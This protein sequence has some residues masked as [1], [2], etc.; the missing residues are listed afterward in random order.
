MLTAPFPAE[1]RVCTRSD[2]DLTDFRENIS[3]VTHIIPRGK[4][5]YQAAAMEELEPFPHALVAAND[6]SRAVG[7]KELVR[8]VLPELHPSPSRRYLA[9]L[10]RPRVRPQHRLK[11]LLHET[12]EGSA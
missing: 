4:E 6:E 5:G 9:A 10:D 12:V 7:P 2:P 11:Y 1:N 8:D 3:R